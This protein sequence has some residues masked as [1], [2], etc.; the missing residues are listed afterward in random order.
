VTP[1]QPS[2]SASEIGWLAKLT[3]KQL[4]EQS[5]AYF[6][7]H[8]L[9]RLAPPHQLSWY[10]FIHTGRRRKHVEAPRGHGKSEALTY[11][12]PLWRLTQNKDLRILIVS[13]NYDQA[14]KYVQRMRAEIEQNSSLRDD[15]GLA[16]HDSLPWRTNLFYIRRPTSLKDPSVEGT[17]VGKAIT[18]GRFDI[19]ICDDILS[20]ENQVSELQRENIWLW[21]TTTLS[22][23]LEPDGR[24]IVI[25]TRKHVSDLY[26]MP[27][28][29]RTGRKG[30]L[31]DPAWDCLVQ[32]AIIDTKRR[33][34]LWPERWT[35]DLL[36]EQKRSIG[37]FAF[38]QEYQ[39]SPV[40]LGGGMFKTEWLRFYTELPKSGIRGVYMGVDPASGISESASY[41]GIV[42][43][44]V[45]DDDEIYVLDLHH[46]RLDPANGIKRVYEKA[47]QY[48]ADQ[49]GVEAVFHQKSLL[50]WMET[51]GIRLP[52]TPLDYR[53]GGSDKS[54]N[55][56]LRILGL[57]PYFERGQIHLPSGDSQTEDFINQ[58]YL[59]FPDS[60]HPDRIDALEMAIRIIPRYQSKFK[61]Y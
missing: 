9:R 17:G 55:K 34:V 12:Y 60:A 32:R 15:F 14:T 29:E 1:R 25:G 45:T 49:I 7:R 51:L 24:F 2:P 41:W 35:Y 59:P 36:M 13:E 54:R 38:S 40:P 58:E 23:I 18:G 27:P 5:C 37:H 21:F 56:V 52:V 48:R 30:L 4:A 57:A 26:G 8:Y 6:A 53:E 47:K 11:I 16:P 61:W 43:I 50:Q 46:D 3:P 19:I 10:D 22:P 33:E 39:N 31:H 28:D 20:T 44:M 42:T